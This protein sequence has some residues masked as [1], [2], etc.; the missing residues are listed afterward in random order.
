MRPQPS[1]R[2]DSRACVLIV[3]QDRVSERAIELALAPAKFSIEW[4]RDGEAALDIMRRLRVEVVISDSLLG[5]MPGITL[6]RRANEA[7]GPGAPAFI[8]VS[9]DRAATTKIGLLLVGA[10]DYLV[11][12][13][14]ADELRVR[15]QNTVELRRRA[16]AENLRG[17]TGLAGD[18]AQ[19]SVPD[20]L[21]MLEMGRKTGALHISVGPTSGQIVIENGALVHAEV[22]NLSG[23]D[24]FFVLLEYNGG[25]Y[26]FVPG[27]VE[28]PGTLRGRV[29]EML[30][31]SAF[32]EDTSRHTLIDRRTDTDASL[33]ELGVV[34]TPI[35]L[36]TRTR[37]DSKP[38]VLAAQTSRLA[39]AVADSYLLG[40]LVLAPEIAPTQ[41]HQFRI[42]LWACQHEALQAMLT[43]ASTPG[44]T[45]IAAA[46]ANKPSSIHLQFETAQASVIVTLVDLEAPRAL[47]TQLPHGV[48]LVPPR[49]ELTTLSPATVARLSARLAEADRPVIV[50][51]GGPA[52]HDVVARMIGDE[53]RLVAMPG[54]FEDLR[55]T[56]GGVI[57]L[58][59]ASR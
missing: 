34:K 41:N 16:R 43:L 21:G 58:W 9:A 32:R 51:F 6:L 17:V 53:L 45:V 29:S 23:Q 11:K 22:G 47:S 5:D 33:R 49:G 7:C 18:A 55:D 40:D 3:D 20:I 54:G 28:I 25:L 37:S 13:F 12:P 59:S 48:I 50:A 36:R 31:E 39:V 44:Y 26:R 14:V 10:S 42:E 1:A 8:F 35:D 57:N 2:A 19:I 15:V 27:R 46:L 56:I 30:L 38:P 24:A 4:A 52:L